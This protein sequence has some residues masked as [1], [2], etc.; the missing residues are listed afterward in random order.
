MATRHNLLT[1]SS[2]R[3]LAPW[4]G[5]ADA[6]LSRHVP[7]A[8]QGDSSLR[9]R[10]SSVAYSGVRA[11]GQIPVNPL[12]PHAASAYVTVPVVPSSSGTASLVLQ[13]IW[14][15]EAGTVVGTSTSPTRTVGVTDGW[16]R[17]TLVAMSPAS[18]A[19]VQFQ[20]VSPVTTSGVQYFAIDAAL[21]EESPF[22]GGWVDNTS[23]D[24]KTTILNNALSAPTAHPIEGLPLRADV[25]IDDLVLNTI[26]EDDTLWVCTDIDGWW[27]GSA[28]EFP[29]VPR[30]TDD[31]DFDMGG[32]YEARVITIKGVFFPAN[33]QQLQRA[34]DRLIGATN[35]VRRGAWFRTNENPTKAAFVRLSGKVLMQTVNARGKTEFSIMLKAADPIRYG[36]NDN[37]NE[38]ITSVVIPEGTT[39]SLVV[40]NQGTAAVQGTIILTG[41]MG[42]GSTVTNIRTAESLRLLRPLRGASLVAAPT[43][44]SIVMGA[45]SLELA[46]PSDLEVGDKII[47]TG[48]GFPFDTMNDPVTVTGV[49][50]NRAPYLVTY[51]IDAPD[52][53]FVN[54]PATGGIRL[55]APDVLAIDTYEKSVTFNGVSIGNR[56]RIDTLVDWIQFMPGDN[57]LILH[58]TFR[59]LDLTQRGFTA[60]RVGT[61]RTENAHYLNVNDQI[62]IN[63]P[64]TVNL[65]TKQLTSNVVTLTTETN[66]GFLPGEKI[67]VVTTELSNI[68]SKSVTSNVATLTTEVAGEFAVGDQVTVSLPTTATIVSKSATASEVTLTTATPHRFSNGDQITVALPVNAQAISRQRTNNVA[69]LTTAAHHNYSVGDQIT[70]SIPDSASVTSKSLSVSTATLTTGAAHGFSVGDTVSLT[71]PTSATLTGARSTSG[72]DALTAT[73]TTSAAHGFDLG[74]Q[75]V[76]S[77]G[78]P[79]VQTITSRVATTTTVTLTTATHNFAV[80]ERIQVAGVGARFDGVA[81]ISAV[82]ATTISYNLPGATTAAAAPPGGATVTNI[83]IRDGYNGI[84]YIDSMTSTTITYFAGVSAS[85]ASSGSGGTGSTLTNS[86]NQ[87]I[88]GSRVITAVPSSTQLTFTRS[89]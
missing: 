60:A 14:R 24:N 47:V 25:L 84:K 74:D 33:E 29:A 2:F 18:A 69:T 15:N 17:L 30:G 27:G 82:T 46:T 3:T 54:A 89:T 72:G 80:G 7:E 77:L 86:T 51:K 28:P 4:E 68:V 65:A 81:T 88:T 16:L 8:V 12:E 21:L 63:I 71:F 23:S 85:T 75:I 31:G 53:P 34:R 32:R 37:D 56:S 62:T 5:V 70:I 36:W 49:S 20:V 78:V 19:T 55:A 41:P 61:I 58:D 1:D 11:A 73:L 42:G 83:T 57:E 64:D 26:D 43:R 38:G 13:L 50:N 6:R 45:A 52:R 40:N 22:V 67:D 66:H 87:S 39:R 44:M 59:Y 79:T 76:V 9:V 10:L 35:L 48:L